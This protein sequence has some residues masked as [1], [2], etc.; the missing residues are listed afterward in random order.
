MFDWVLN[1]P[2]AGKGRESQPLKKIN[3]HSLPYF[4]NV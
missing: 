4:R 3:K 1:M 2:L